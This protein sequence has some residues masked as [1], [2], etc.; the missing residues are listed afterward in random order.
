MIVVICWSSET[1]SPT[2]LGN[3]SFSFLQKEV[4]IQIKVAQLFESKVQD[5]QLEMA[6]QAVL[7]ER[8][9]RL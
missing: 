3:Q 6:T 7:D 9:N 2:Q 4:L 5:R 8:A 1:T